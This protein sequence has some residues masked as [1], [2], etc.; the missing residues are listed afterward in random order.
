MLGVV[1]AAGRGSRMA[2]L[3]TELPKALVPTLDTPQLAWV[4]ASLQRIGLE[5]LWVNA[6]A[7]HEAIDRVVAQQAAEREMAIEVSHERAVA[8]GT[9]GALR[10]LA[11]HLTGPFLVANADVATDLPVERL[12]EAHAS[13]KAAATVLAIPVEDEADFA[14]EQ[15]WVFDLIDRREEI[16]SGHRFGGLAI[17]EPEVLAYI[18]DGEQGLYETVF[19]GLL[20]D[21]KGFAALEWDGYWLD[22][23]TP[24]DHLKANLDVLAG[25]RDPKLATRAVGETCV[26]WDVMAYVG[27][28]AQVTDVDLRHSI[29]G[30]HATV[31]PGSRLERCVVWSGAHLPRGD[32]R[33]TIVTRTHQLPLR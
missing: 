13:A 12:M 20:R 33:D 7:D 4:L 17:F 11:D 1:L 6:H 19:K 14:L 25:M 26:R 10:P 3:S 22:I 30:A 29:V 2:P 18:P 15:S 31:A 28:G 32:Y 8:L 5:R 24:R 27:E 16:R 23:G 9:A 21:H